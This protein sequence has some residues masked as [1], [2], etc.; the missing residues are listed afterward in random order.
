MTTSWKVLEVHRGGW[1]VVYICGEEPHL[2]TPVI[3]IKTLAPLPQSLTNALPPDRLFALNQAI[4]RRFVTECLVAS[5]IPLHSNIV[6][7]YCIHYEE[8]Q[9]LLLMELVNAGSLRRLT[10][11]GPLPISDSVRT[12]IHIC[13]GLQHAYEQRALLHRDIKPENVLI[14]SDGIAK[15]CDFGL[16]NAIDGELFTA[17]RADERTRAQTYI[18]RSHTVGTPGYMSPEQLR[19]PRNLTV[20]SDVFSF[21]VLLYELLTGTRPFHGSSIPEVLQ[22]WSTGLYRPPRQLNPNVP[23][24]LEA[25]CN[26]CLST[27]P[28]HRFPSYSALI[29]ALE[30]LACDHRIILPGLSMPPEVE[31]SEFELGRQALCLAESGENMKVVS[32]LNQHPRECERSARLLHIKGSALGHMGE[33]NEAIKCF[34]KAIHLGWP[35][36]WSTW[37]NLGNSYRRL[38]QDAEA[39][40]CYETSLSIKPRW[41]KPILALAELSAEAGDTENAIRYCEKA[42]ELNPSV[43]AWFVKANILIGDGRLSEAQKWLE[44]SPFDPTAYPRVYV[45][46][47][48]IQRKLGQNDAAQSSLG[49]Y[50]ALTG[51][52]SLGTYNEATT[53]SDEALAGARAQY[54]ASTPHGSLAAPDIDTYLARWPHDTELRYQK[55]QTLVER[56]PAKALEVFTELANEVPNVG[57]FLNAAGCALQALG[58]NAEALEYVERACH[59][60]PL[61]VTF[62]CNRARLL[63]CL[64]RPQ[65]AIAGLAVFVE[66]YP[67]DPQVL[68]LLGDSRLRT[69]D[70]DGA[71]KAFTDGLIV[72]PYSRECLMGCWKVARARGDIAQALHYIGRVL[73]QNPC[74]SSAWHNR[75]ETLISFGRLEEASTCYLNAIALDSRAYH[76][77]TSL[78]FVYACWG[79][80]MLMLQYAKKACEI[81]PGFKPA[82]MNARHAELRVIASQLAERTGVSD[83]DTFAGIAYVLKAAE[84]ARVE[85]WDQLD[86]IR[87]HQGKD[88]M[89]ASRSLRDWREEALRLADDGRYSEAATIFRRILAVA[90]GDFGS[91]HAL[92]VCL[93]LL[94]EHTESLLCFDRALR[95]ANECGAA[96]HETLNSRGEALRKLGRDT[97]AMAMYAAVLEVDPE[98]VFAWV[99]KGICFKNQ[100]R[101]GDAERCYEKA[102][103][104]DGDSWIALVNYANLRTITGKVDEAVGLCERALRV[105]HGKMAVHVAAAAAYW[106]IG[107][108]DKAAT[109]LAIAKRICP[110]DPA[111]LRMARAFQGASDDVPAEG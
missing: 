7:S 89:F 91:W 65:D 105:G 57:R 24:G 61:D 111:V 55:A 60:D 50:V 48:H 109:Q 32:L 18:V 22:H 42:L 47:A 81:C 79:D 49:S 33:D 31:R 34:T 16:A 69:G 21:G 3:A 30:R 99:N 25:L 71:Q 103:S 93:D 64:E 75:G 58:N 1:G 101:Y 72:S 98:H 110:D 68:G 51:D 14:D 108:A 52:V 56:D 37:F 95:L 15:I 90:T 100:G 80:H 82:E 43:S 74:D 27:L 59:T 28:D 54:L 67:N 11:S 6:T 4:H 2:D 62:A 19:D 106:N 39:R 77:M 12:A 53:P 29:T 96:S 20:A 41:P 10:A 84:G 76:A 94:G 36:V 87:R 45:L 44:Q 8:G 73:A 83:D 13:R 86:A 88:A 104:V 107:D 97:E 70:I 63:L 35:F 9:P 5:S 78:S 40:R 23:A 92:G 85:D 38:G 66:R 102:L 26:T 17:M 46:M